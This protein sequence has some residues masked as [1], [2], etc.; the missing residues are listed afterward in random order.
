MP[1][2][3]P[4]K[5]RSRGFNL[6]DWIGDR[7]TRDSFRIWIEKFISVVIVIDLLL[8]G[9]NT[10][11]I[12][13][14]LES[15]VTFLNIAIQVIF[16]LDCLRII[17]IKRDGVFKD[18]WALSDCL[19]TIITIIPIGEWSQYSRVI[20]SIRVI[21]CI[22]VFS[23]VEELKS[24]IKI[25][26]ESSIGVF[27]TT[28]LLLLLMY[29]YGIVGTLMYGITFDEWFGSLWRSI[30]TLFQIITLEAWSDSIARSV[31][32]VYPNSWVYFVSFVIISAFIVM[33]IVIGIVVDTITKTHLEEKQKPLKENLE[34]QNLLKES[35]E[36]DN[37]SQTILSQL[38]NAKEYLKN[39]KKQTRP[40][41]SRHVDENEIEQEKEKRILTLGIILTNSMEK[42]EELFKEFVK[43]FEESTKGK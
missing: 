11:H 9:V 31:M 40:E 43:S 28:V 13:E 10:F 33:N 27:W 17:L 15:V 30:Y 42:Q 37:K 32:A 23:H 29:C 7:L 24:L 2:P 22:R 21:R 14:F 4:V 8:L 16:F 39:G 19:I 26:G 1:N 41:E 38:G 35:S 34:K 20:R 3:L 12:P 36:K 18:G 6:L 25:I 5:D